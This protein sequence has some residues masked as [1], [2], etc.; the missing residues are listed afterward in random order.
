MEICAGI[1]GLPPYQVEIV[2][3][4]GLLAEVNHTGL[5]G[6][7]WLAREIGLAASQLRGLDAHGCGELLELVRQKAC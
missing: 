2:G 7:F 4:V 5:G 1:Q 6:L 3:G